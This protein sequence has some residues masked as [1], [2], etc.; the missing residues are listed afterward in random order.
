MS[1]NVWNFNINNYQL[2]QMCRGAG[3]CFETTLY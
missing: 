3:S 2:V 1:K